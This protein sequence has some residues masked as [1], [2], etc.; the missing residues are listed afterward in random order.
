MG[1]VRG[2][3]VKR[4]P[5]QIQFPKSQNDEVFKKMEM[6]NDMEGMKMRKSIHFEE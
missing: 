3:S 4:V 1:R 6:R 5:T 2:L